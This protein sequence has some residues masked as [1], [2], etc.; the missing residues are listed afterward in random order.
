MER[1]TKNGTATAGGSRESHVNGPVQGRPHPPCP[2]HTFLSSINPHLR[3]P[4][5]S[6]PA[7]NLQRPV[8]A[9]GIQHFNRKNVVEQLGKTRQIS[10]KAIQLFGRSI[11]RH[12]LFKLDSVSIWK[13]VDL[14]PQH[15]S[16]RVKSRGRARTSDKDLDFSVHVQTPKLRVGR[17]LALLPVC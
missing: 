6:H 9:R 5:E 10:P 12:R 1:K 13:S 11:D 14:L 17:L 8:R 16:H 7:R 3:V 4:F 15:A 2:P